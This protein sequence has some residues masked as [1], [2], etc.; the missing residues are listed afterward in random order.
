[1]EW[2]RFVTYLSNDPRINSIFDYIF[3][4]ESR[5]SNKKFWARNTAVQCEAK[6]VPKQKLHFCQKLY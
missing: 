5:G 6:S 1:M 4:T 2:R 3:L